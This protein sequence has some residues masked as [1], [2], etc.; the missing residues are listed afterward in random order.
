MVVASTRYVTS[1]TIRFK[2]LQSGGSVLSTMAAYSLVVPKEYGYVL[3]V[4]VGSAIVNMWLAFRVGRAR[5]RFDVK[6]PAMY[7]DTNV[8]FNCIQR[9]H[10]NF[11]ESY[12]QFLMMLFLGGLEYPRLAACAGVVYLAGRIVYAIGYSTGGMLVV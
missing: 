2:V 4:G 6:Y 5:K 7:S 11:L 3:F 1:S 9:S 8:V 12:P 10:Q